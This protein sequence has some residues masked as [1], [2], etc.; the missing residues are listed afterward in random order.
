MMSNPENYD[1]FLIH[2]SR[3][4]P[5]VRTLV[6]TLRGRG[7]SVWFDEERLR[8]GSL[9]N[10]CWKRASATPEVSPCWWERVA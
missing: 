8:P 10:C 9:G 2:N 1:C 3:D 5:V 4:K 7:I 6:K